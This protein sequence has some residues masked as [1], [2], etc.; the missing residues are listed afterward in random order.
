MGRIKTNKFRLKH[1]HPKTSAPSK[2]T[3]GGYSFT[4]LFILSLLN[5][6]PKYSNTAVQIRILHVNLPIEWLAFFSVCSALLGKNPH[7]TNAISGT[8]MI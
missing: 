8:D 4:C 2:R 6:R 3:V 1:C 5:S 7:K